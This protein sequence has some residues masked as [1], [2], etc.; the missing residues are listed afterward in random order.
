[1]MGWFHMNKK[2][3]GLLGA[4]VLGLASAPAIAGGGIY[5]K[6]GLA[7][8]GM[9]YAHGVDSRFTLRGDFTTI[10][11]ISHRGSVGD[12]RYK[13]RAKNDTLNFYGDWFPFD[14]GFRLTA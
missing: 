8:V 12:F 3:A 1:M 4:L 13:A 9:G 5:F 11:Q 2:V 6:G 7:G 10:D 14:N